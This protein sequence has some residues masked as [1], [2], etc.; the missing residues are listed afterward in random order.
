M[1]YYINFV[2]QKEH[3]IGQDHSTLL[4]QVVHPY[5]EAHQIFNKIIVHFR[6]VK[7]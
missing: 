3:T 4:P 6:D 7:V 2:Q 1:L 5:Q